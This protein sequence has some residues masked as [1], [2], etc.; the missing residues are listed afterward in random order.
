MDKLT[1]QIINSVYMELFEKMA[2]KDSID[3]TLLAVTLTEDFKSLE[4]D[5]VQVSNLSDET[6]SETFKLVQDGKTAKESLIEIFTWLANNP[7]GAPKDAL[8]ALRL[9]MISDEEI[10]AL[11][12]TKVNENATMIVKMGSRAFGP[13]M[14]M[15]MKDVRGRAEAQTVQKLLREAIE[16]HA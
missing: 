6:I 2:N 15:I 9:G 14:G 12:E 7:K 3:T 1:N 8:V 16:S 11:V 4:R 5:G 13:L 10:R